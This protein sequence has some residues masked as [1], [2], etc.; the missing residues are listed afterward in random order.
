LKVF[1]KTNPNTASAQPLNLIH[2]SFASLE[3]HKIGG[4][5]RL[6]REIDE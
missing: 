3:S 1:P 4:I 6:G 5:L 2:I